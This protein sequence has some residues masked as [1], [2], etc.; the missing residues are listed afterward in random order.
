MTLIWGQLC[1]RRLP[2]VMFCTGVG[3]GGVEITDTQSETGRSCALHCCAPPGK[4][5]ILL[6]T[7]VNPITPIS[8]FENQNVGNMVLLLQSFNPLL[9]SIATNQRSSVVFN[10]TTATATILIHNKRRFHSPTTFPPD[11]LI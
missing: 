11:N 8:V 2:G 4:V 5:S 9:S 3:A 6:Q 10:K 7:C 1:T